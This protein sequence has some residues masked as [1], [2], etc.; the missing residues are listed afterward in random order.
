[1][2]GG[3]EGGKA[4]QQAQQQQASAVNGKYQTPLLLFLNH[5]FETFLTID[6][7][8]HY[9]TTNW[10][11]FCQSN[12]KFI[13]V[14]TPGF[15]QFMKHGGCGKELFER[16]IHSKKRFLQALSLAVVHKDLICF[17]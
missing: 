14:L 1:M 17:P 2:R 6:T 11:Q 15:E 8:T 3:R 5:H 16:C 12:A 9:K 13:T 7:T 4:K 10:H